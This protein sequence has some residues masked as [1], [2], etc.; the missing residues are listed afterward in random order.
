[1]YQRFLAD[2][3]RHALADTPVVFIGGPRQSGKS[4]LAQILADEHGSNRY[5]TFDASDHYMAAS[6]D[7]DGF[8]QDHESLQVIDEIQRLP[9]LFLPLKYEVDQKRRPG[10]FLLT[11]SANI[12]KVPKIQDSLAGRIE[13]HTLYPLATEE[14]YG[15]Q[16]ELVDTLFRGELPASCLV[17]DEDIFDR[18]LK[19]G[20][21]EVQKRSQKRREAWFGSY[22]ST[23]LER[24]VRDIADIEGSVQLR[25]LI[26]VLAIRSGALLNFEELSRTARIPATTLK[27]YLALLDTLYLVHQLSPWL[28]NRGKRLV[29]RPKIHLLDTGVMS[30][31]LR[32]D[33]RGL[34]R[35]R[36]RLGQILE[37]FVVN[38]ILKRTGWS[39]QQVS[40]HHY[41][42]STGEEVDL[43]LEGR[44]GHVVGIEVKASERVS[45]D[46]TKGLRSLNDAC[47]DL[48]VMG[49]VYYLGSEVKKLGNKLWALPIT[50]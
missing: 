22:V 38:E 26:E 32:I 13:M 6:Q 34:Q 10:R 43:V 2:Q 29:K 15:K 37:T 45:F 20:Y 46:D 40:C 11:G 27:R 3:I 41:R 5:R 14:I 17:Q 49:V 23:L 19:G 12:L 28:K 1:M 24:D 48:F 36:V 16:G 33:R 47:Q 18:L 35:D 30:N 39:D 25:L 21:P 9:E 42:T 31:L 44:G 8:V 4:T 50:S 7:P